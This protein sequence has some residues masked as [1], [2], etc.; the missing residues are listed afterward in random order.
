[1]DDESGNGLVNRVKKSFKGGAR[2]GFLGGEGGGEAPSGSRAERK[3]SE[4]AL[5]NG[6]AADNLKDA[7]GAASEGLTKQEDSLDA[8]RKSEQDG[9]GLYTGGAND[10]AGKIASAAQDI[11]KG[12][13]KG[14]FKKVGPAVGIL[15]IIFVVGG[16]MAGTQLFQPFS[17]VAQFQDSFNSMHTSAYNRSA[18]FLRY[19]MDSGRNKDPRKGTIFGSQKFVLSKKQIA[20]YEQQGIKYNDNY[21]GSG[22]RV[23]EYETEGGQKRIVA[24]TKADSDKLRNLGHTNALSFDAAL[25][26][27]TFSHKFTAASQTW[28]GQFANWFGTNT[29]E[30]LKKNKLTRNMFKDWKQKKEEASKSGKSTLDLVKETIKSKMVDSTGGGVSRKVMED[31]RDKDGNVILDEDGNPMKKVS[32][33]SAITK[34][35]KID[36]SNIGKKLNSLKG[37][38]DAGS[39]ANV[40]CAVAD[41][42]GVVNL[43]VAAEEARQIL[44]IVTPYMEA[45]D[46][47]KAGYGDEAPINELATTLNEQ[48]V[49]DHE[50]IVANGGGVS[51]QKEDG[52]LKSAMQSAGM[53][54]LFGNGLTDPKDASVQSFNLTSNMSTLLGGVG[55]SMASFRACTVARATA[56][57]ASAGVTVASCAASLG[58]GCAIDVLAEFGKGIAIGLAIQGVIDILTPWL[59]STLGRDLVSELAGEDLGNALVSGA[60]MYHGYIHKANGGSLATREKYEEFTIAKQQVIAEEA[61][62]ER[63]SLSPF[64]MTSKNTFMGSLMTQ[65][66]SFNAS[67]SL[68]STLTS[69]SSVMGS[70]L[71]KLLPSISAVASQIAETLPSTEDYA[72][73]CPYLAEIGAVGDSFCNPYMVT[74]MSTMDEDPADII[75]ELD[76]GDNFEKQET[77]DGNVKIK[78]GSELMKYITYCSER[79]SPFGVA[80]QEIIAGIKGGTGNST[81]DTIIGAAP[82]LGD[83]V[84]IYEDTETIGYMGYI[85]GQSCVAGNNLGNDALTERTSAWGAASQYQRFIEDQSLAES[86]GI[87]EKSAVTVALEE[88]YEEN[89]LDETYEGQLARW[90]G[91]D[92]E[93]VS[94]LLD[95]V[96]YYAYVDNYDASERY[97]FGGAVVDENEKTLQFGQEDVMG[98]MATMIE[99]IVYADVRNRTFMI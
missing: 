27:S 4:R 77:S 95:V 63:E 19:Q 25:N 76:D 16:V 88:Y 33:K 18:K 21:E 6:L 26:D 74:D 44:N 58:V 69:A 24:A 75:A 20:K 56:A 79:T 48:T 7:E 49:T 29:G 39:V 97:A 37:S 10:K 28:R 90:S 17:M 83:I 84:E 82:V 46:K 62:E 23:L 8:A 87:I 99:G 89:P 93:T 15:L 3:A 54:A 61:R 67:S 85:S 30:F 70:S 42:V 47:T 13:F 80:D 1:M 72:Q 50:K 12:N 57:I 86:M 45:V 2:P 53:A 22:I 40:G 71:T 68:M 92:K 78:K 73:I 64:D 31:A 51:S 94:D 81:A 35:S 9:G 14:A 98:G 32:D 38:F 52:K 66:M 59:V 41:F 55:I 34:S 11:K 36:A 65:L 5:T 43:M 96:A 60:N 91:L